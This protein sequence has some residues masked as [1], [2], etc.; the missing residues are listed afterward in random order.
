MNKI[1]LGIRKSDGKAEVYKEL[2]INKIGS[3]TILGSLT[4]ILR[5]EEDWN[6]IIS[7]VLWFPQSTKE[8]RKI[9][10]GPKIISIPEYVIPLLIED[11]LE[12]KQDGRFNIEILMI[13]VLNE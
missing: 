13:E 8:F 3:N 9:N 6:K 7:I 5:Q 2:D 11:I 12:I 4:E 10:N 1:L